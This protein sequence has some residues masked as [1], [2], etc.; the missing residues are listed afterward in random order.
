MIPKIIWAIFFIISAATIATNWSPQLWQYRGAA[1]LGKYALWVCFVAFVVYGLYA[2]RRED[3]FK[4]LRKIGA[5]YWGKQIAIDLYIG[6]AFFLIFI[7]W[8]Q[9]IYAALLW[10]LPVL[11][12]GNQLTLL[13]LAVHYDSIFAK[14]LTAV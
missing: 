4:A 3:F 8:H 6:F 12:Y 10:A 13:Y 2:T 1:S 14:L 5:Y 9:G 11:V 7:G